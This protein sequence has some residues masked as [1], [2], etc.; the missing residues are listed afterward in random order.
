[1]VGNIPARHCTG[2]RLLAVCLAAAAAAAAA[3]A[4]AR[5]ADEPAHTLSLKGTCTFGDRT[6]TWS[7]VLTPKGEGIYDA[8]YV[9]SWGG[10][11]LHY[12]GTVR[13]DLKTEI[14]GSGK[15]SGG[16]ANGTFEFAGTYGDDGVATCSYQEV[17]GRG[18]GGSLTAEMPKPG[19]SATPG[20]AKPADD[21]T[22]PR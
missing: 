1:M 2:W 21:A 10:Q 6:S 3:T 16:R 9:S 13:T 14:S 11:P 4:S 17:G 5:A 19:A 22:A 18:R 20:G 12:V 15:A 8:V 7:A